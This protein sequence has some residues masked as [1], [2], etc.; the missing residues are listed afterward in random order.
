VIDTPL[1]G[2]YFI[3][4]S[5]IIV[6]HLFALQAWLDEAARLESAAVDMETSTAIGDYSRNR[7]R[8]RCLQHRRRFPWLQV[9][10]LMSAIGVIAALAVQTALAL[11]G[12]PWRLSI[13]PTAVLVL[14]FV[15]ATVGTGVEGF[16]RLGRA[17]KRLE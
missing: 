11:S 1:L 17:A 4:A 10:M 2:N 15:V 3:L 5:I 8:Q 12:V 14:V 13:T 16:R 6:Y 9:I 7:L